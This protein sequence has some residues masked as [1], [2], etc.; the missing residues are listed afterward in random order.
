MLCSLSGIFRDSFSNL[1][2]LLDDVLLEAAT[3]EDERPEDNFI[4]K[5]YL[6]MQARGVAREGA[7]ARLFSNP[8]GDF[9]S[10]VG[11]QV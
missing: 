3:R 5:H 8:A 11:D 6:E 7:S 1:L 10:L 9:G 2:Q 4:R